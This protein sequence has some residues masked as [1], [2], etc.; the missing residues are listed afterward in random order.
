MVTVIAAIAMV[1]SLVAGSCYSGG[2]IVLVT[3][4]CEVIAF[5]MVVA[6]TAW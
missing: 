6:A 3:I 1:A 4:V 5:H 2:T